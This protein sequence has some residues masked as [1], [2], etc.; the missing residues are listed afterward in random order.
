MNDTTNS[1]FKYNINIVDPITGFNVA[2][3]TFKIDEIK[4]AFQEGLDIIIGNL[5][6]INIKEDNLSINDTNINLNNNKIL[7]H[8]FFDK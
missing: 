5:Y 7:E 2:K 8:F 1:L 6:K 3:S 4:K